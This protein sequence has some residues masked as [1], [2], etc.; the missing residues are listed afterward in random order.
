MKERA[1]EKKE[2]LKWK[3]GCQKAVWLYF[4][5]IPTCQATFNIFLLNYLSL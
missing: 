5:D 2:E 4:L 3:C 1:S